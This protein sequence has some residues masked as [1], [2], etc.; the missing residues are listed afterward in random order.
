[1]LKRQIWYEIMS[2]D[3]KIMSTCQIRNWQVD[4]ISLGI[5][6]RKRIT[7]SCCCVMPQNDKI[8]F[9]SSSNELL[10]TVKLC[11]LIQRDKKN[12]IYFEWFYRH[13][14]DLLTVIFL[15]YIFV[16]IKKGKEYSRNSI[17]RELIMSIWYRL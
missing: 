10:I 3:Q 4:G 5:N 11:W 8:K 9:V 17:Q 12:S 13:V 15:R 6:I 7:A 14:Q 16:T 2:T 1:M